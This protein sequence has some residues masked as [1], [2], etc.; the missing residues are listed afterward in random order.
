MK[1]EERREESETTLVEGNKD[2]MTGYV[3]EMQKKVQKLTLSANDQSMER[4][5]ENPSHP[6]DPRKTM[7]RGEG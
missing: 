7:R 1:N 6:W 4:V 3:W 2:A 5:I